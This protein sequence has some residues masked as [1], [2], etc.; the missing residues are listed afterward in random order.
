MVRVT[1]GLT[2]H[3]RHRKFVKLATW[4][5]LGRKNVYKQVRT[6]L[7]KQWTNA[8]AWRKNKKRDF[9][10]LWI[11]RLSA[12]IRERGWKYSIF[13]DQML[14]NNIALDRKVLSNISVVFP[15]VFDKI[16]NSIT[17][18][19]IEKPK[20]VDV[21]SVKDEKKAQP[22]ASVSS[23]KSKTTSKSS[24]VKKTSKPSVWQV[25]EVKKEKSTI[26][27]TTAKKT[28]ASTKAKKTTKK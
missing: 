15:Q 1:N 18:W 16:Y 22:K 21:W 6:A 11:E 3:K 5:R 28:V 26:K 20:K 12:A 9:R 27:K 17:T 25:K 2:R 19:K 10:Q 4:F 13:M 24:T 14:K 8:Y 23:E 7:I